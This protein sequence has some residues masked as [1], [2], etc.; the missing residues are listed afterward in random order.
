[1]VPCY[2]YP[3][4]TLYTLRAHTSDLRMKVLFKSRARLKTSQTFGVQP[5]PPHHAVE[6]DAVVEPSLRLFGFR[7]QGS[8]SSGFSV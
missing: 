1:M 7:V 5:G 6:V 2:I 4:Y 8:K 3:F